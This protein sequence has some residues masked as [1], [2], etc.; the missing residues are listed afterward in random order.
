MVVDSLRTICVGLLVRRVSSVV[1]SV[2]GWIIHKEG[3]VTESEGKG[4]QR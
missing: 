3:V 1:A 4:I 2:A